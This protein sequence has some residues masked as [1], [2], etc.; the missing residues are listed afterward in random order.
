MPL[1]QKSKKTTPDEPAGAGTDKAGQFIKLASW[2]RDNPWSS[3]GVVIL[4]LVGYFGYQTANNLDAVLAAV[5][6]SP[7]VE[8]T[9]FHLAIGRGN[10]IG[11]LLENVRDETDASRLLVA[12][13]HN[14]KSNLGAVPWS[15]SSTRYAAV[16]PGISYDLDGA[17]SIP[18]SMF[19]ETF[20]QMWLDPKKP[21]CIYIR[22]KD[23][24]SSLQRAQLNARGT[25]AFIQCPLQ[26]SDGTPLGTVVAGFVRFEPPHPE[27]I[28]TKVQALA[29]DL[30]PLIGKE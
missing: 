6:P 9:S 20:G 10:K 4:G 18:N 15:F 24:R 28:M 7:K 17:Q 14:G 19:A 8:T 21:K 22:T 25:T 30:V 11:A 16:A 13:F 5:K 2:V 27:E 26:R 3:I 12:E 23:V 1:S 29:A